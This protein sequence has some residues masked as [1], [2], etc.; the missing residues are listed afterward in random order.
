MQTGP[1]G[2]TVYFKIDGAQYSVGG[3]FTFKPAKVSREP[4]VGLSGTPNYT[5]KPVVQQVDCELQH[6]ADLDPMNL[7]DLKGVTL[8]FEL[9]NG[10]SYLLSNAYQ[11]GEY[12]VD[13]AEGSI[14]VTFVGVMTRN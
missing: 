9:V 11:S 10:Q 5:E 4:K 3:K 8:T 2:G 13:A 1:I 7:N 14:P 6:T 12:E